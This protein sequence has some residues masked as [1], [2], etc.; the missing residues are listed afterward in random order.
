MH[1]KELFVVKNGDKIKK[2]C[3]EKNKSKKKDLEN[4]ETSDSYEI[5]LKI[6]KFKNNEKNR[7]DEKEKN[8][9]DKKNNKNE[10]K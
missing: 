2:H 6:W 10:K 8:S 4:N 3:D 1:D 5:D 7:D 9:D